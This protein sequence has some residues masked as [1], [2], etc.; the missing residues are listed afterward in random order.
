MASAEYVT[1]SRQRDLSSS[2]VS[3]GAVIAGAFVAT[4]FSLTLLALFA[5]FELSTLSPWSNARTSASAVRTSGLVCLVITQ[6]IASAIG[7]YLVGRLR[8]RWDAVHL[9]EV[10][11]RD[12][13]NG[14]LSW[15]VAVV[16]TVAFLTSAAARMAGGAAADSEGAAGN[17]A[18]REYDAG[19]NAYFVDRLFRGE[20]PGLEGEAISRA[21][22]GRILDTALHRPQGGAPDT[23]YLALVVATRTGLS[24]SDAQRR[25]TE[26][27]G[28]AQQSLDAARKG[29]ARILLW[30]FFALLIGA[31][32]ASFAATVGGRQ[33]DRV[34]AI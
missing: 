28:E 13:A 12:T 31:F 21:E 1:Y 14:F 17:R 25:V 32:C 26:T 22:A 3:W 33:R 7:G 29:T 2:G 6:I 18:E 34:E 23:D 8:N 9:D 24:M 4:A 5:G 16:L 30:T 10:H 11:F 27:L 20:R 19:P 15:A